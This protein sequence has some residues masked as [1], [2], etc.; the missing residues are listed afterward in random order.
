MTIRIAA[1]AFDPM[2]LHDLI[3]W[4]ADDEAATQRFLGRFVGTWNQA[5]YA[6]QTV[7]DTDEL[8]FTAQFGL[9]SD[10]LDPDTSRAL[11]EAAREGACGAAYCIAGEAVIADRRYRLIYTKYG[12]NRLR[13]DFCIAQQPTGRFD[14]D[15]R[16]LYED[17][18]G[19]VPEEIHN[20]G[21]RNLGLTEDE[22]GWLFDADRDLTTLREVANLLCENRGMALMFPGEEVFEPDGRDY[23][24]D[25]GDDY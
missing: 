11:T 1:P 2:L 14:R 17:V 24:D 3:D 6:S 21:A 18:P 9:F 15:G 25:Y 23:D 13:A 16:V 20:V 12:D 7:D 19:A 4:A 5:L 22:A 8:E 10:A